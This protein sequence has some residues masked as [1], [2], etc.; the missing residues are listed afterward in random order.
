MLTAI[1][2]STA[3]WCVKLLF[4]QSDFKSVRSAQQL[5]CCWRF[6]R[7]QQPCPQNKT[8]VLFL[9]LLLE[10]SG[11]VLFWWRGLVFGFFF[12]ERPRPKKIVILRVSKNTTNSLRRFL[13]LMFLLCFK[14]FMSQYSSFLSLKSGF[15]CNFLT[16]LAFHTSRV[17][18]L[19]WV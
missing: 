5:D 1:C 3:K 19:S 14:N 17:F 18:N 16:T 11:G 15:W 8:Q 13:L 7:P 12:F 9:G 2:I 6:A 4:S 10:P